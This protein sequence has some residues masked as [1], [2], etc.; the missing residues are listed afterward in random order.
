MSWETLRIILFFLALTGACL[1]A[2]IKAPVLIPAFCMLLVFFI[3][4]CAIV[5][6]LEEYCLEEGNDD[7]HEEK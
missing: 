2:I 6:I 3:G 4:A 7:D 5:W 1:Y